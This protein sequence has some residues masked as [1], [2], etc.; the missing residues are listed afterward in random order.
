MKAAQS[1][2]MRWVLDEEAIDREPIT[3][4]MI[5]KMLG[6]VVSKQQESAECN[7]L[8]VTENLRDHEILARFLSDSS[9]CSMLSK[10]SSS[11]QVEPSSM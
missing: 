2:E 6:E 8:A 5:E 7:L 10:L 11:F 1:F 3:H 9:L 4:L